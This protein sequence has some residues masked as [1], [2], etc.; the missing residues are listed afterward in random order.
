M[1]AAEHF[2]DHLKRHLIMDE[3]FKYHWQ[4]IIKF[5]ASMSRLGTNYLQ[6]GIIDCLSTWRMFIEGFNAAHILCYFVD[7]GDKEDEIG[8]KIQHELQV[9]FGHRHCQHTVLVGSADSSYTGFLRQYKTE[10]VLCGCVTLVE[11]VP[12]PG[13]FYKLASPFLHKNKDSLFKE[14]P[15]EHSANSPSGRRFPSAKE[16]NRGHSSGIPLSLRPGPTPKHQQTV[17]ASFSRGWSASPSRGP[18][19]DLISPTKQPPCSASPAFHSREQSVS[20]VGSSPRRSAPPIRRQLW[21]LTGQALE[22]QTPLLQHRQQ[23]R[24]KPL[25]N[26]QP[27]AAQVRPSKPKNAFF[28]PQGQRIDSGSYSSMY[29]KRYLQW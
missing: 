7:A 25:A 24:R 16:H 23:V 15:Q 18:P 6:L 17:P 14:K 8:D 28:S 11:A 19:E 10:D 4:L 26:T 2:H 3:V 12:S 13:E 21:P 1:R 22:L 20:L 29:T 5:Y 27:R 9:L